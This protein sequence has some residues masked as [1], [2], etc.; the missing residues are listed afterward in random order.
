MISSQSVPKSGEG[1]GAWLLKIL[2]GLLVIVIL[3]IHFVVNHTLGGMAGL[4]TYTEIV[5]YYAR[6]PIIPIMEGL[7][8][9]FVVT[10]ALL[11][12]RS[13]ILDMKPSTK[14]LKVINWVFVIGG[15]AFIIYGLGLIITIVM[16]GL[17]V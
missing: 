17:Q 11:G 5:S 3:G 7:F 6:N 9:I 10:H 16:R 12:L 13:I 8:V 4:L 2:T 14:A 1:S 15:A